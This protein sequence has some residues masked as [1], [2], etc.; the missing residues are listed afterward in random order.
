[1]KRNF[2]VT[3]GL[4]DAWEFN[5]NNFLLGTWCEFYEFGI[6]EKEKLI[7]KI[8]KKISII[9]NI[10]HWNDSKKNRLV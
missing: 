10:Y 1:M 3:T 7:N 8:P 9:K 5:E 2:L 4:I 6:Y